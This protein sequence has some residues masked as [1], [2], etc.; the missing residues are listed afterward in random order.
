MYLLSYVRL[1]RGTCVTALIEGLKKRDTPLLLPFVTSTVLDR[2]LSSTE[3][4]THTLRGI[5]HRTTR[6]IRLL[7]NEWFLIEINN[8][9]QQRTSSK[10][11][12]SRVMLSQDEE[13]RGRIKLMRHNPQEMRDTRRGNKYVGDQD[14]RRLTI[15]ACD[16]NVLVSEFVNKKKID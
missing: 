15:A 2:H 14:T 11:C 7:E 8:R 1:S 5:K 6:E 3:H 4:A 10:S 9:I 13:G 16:A 12:R